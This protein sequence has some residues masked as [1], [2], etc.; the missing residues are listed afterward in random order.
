VEG[1]VFDL[2]ELR[3]MSP[4]QRNA[5]KRA[6][7]ELDDVH[8]LNDPRLRRRRRVGLT[9]STAACV[10]LIAWIGY[11]A[12]ALPYTYRATDWR[13]TWAGF[14]VLLLAGLGATAW[15]S[16]RRRQVLMVFA[17][18]TAALLIC[19][20]WF[21]I[22]LSWGTGDLPMSIFSALCGEL[23]I[24][25]ALLTA[26]HRIAVTSLAITRLHSGQVGPLPPLRKVPLFITD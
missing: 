1:T 23:P 24:A 19:D 14:D 18:A 10:F 21:D 13:F 2:E 11:L 12:V 26:V 16:W 3:A 8:P 7:A 25:L 6:L 20:A 22:T 17:T 4:E 15:A 9:Y 5:L